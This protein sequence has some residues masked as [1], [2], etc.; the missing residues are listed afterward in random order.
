[1]RRVCSSPHFRFH[2]GSSCQLHTII[3]FAWRRGLQHLESNL[4]DAKLPL[5]ASIERRDLRLHHHHLCFRARLFLSRRIASISSVHRW[6]DH[7]RGQHLHCPTRATVEQNYSG[8]SSDNDGPGVTSTRQRPFWLRKDLVRS[9][10]AAFSFIDLPL[11]HGEC[12]KIG[13]AQRRNVRF[14]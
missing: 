7:S 6:C 11:S 1:M 5:R 2:S 3:G 12:S 8:G 9:L 14:P 13:F 4:Y 10:S